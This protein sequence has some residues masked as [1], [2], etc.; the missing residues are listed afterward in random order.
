MWQE[1]YYI[2]HIDLLSKGPEFEDMKMGYVSK[3]LPVPRIQR[4]H[5]IMIKKSDNTT[6][7]LF[8]L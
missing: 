5:M 6:R 8:G 2:R 3:M 1:L 4:F 7:E